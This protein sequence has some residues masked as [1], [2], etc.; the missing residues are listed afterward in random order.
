MVAVARK[1]QGHLLCLAHFWEVGG[2]WVYK[3]GLAKVF[4]E[5]LSQLVPCCLTA[6]FLDQADGH[7]CG[8]GL[9]L[10]P[11]HQSGQDLI[12]LFGLREFIYSE[13]MLRLVLTGF[14]FVIGDAIQYFRK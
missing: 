4:D 6:V 11:L 3:V 5:L 9:R 10:E 14:S 13:E 2:C 8:Q 7:V 1:F 12:P